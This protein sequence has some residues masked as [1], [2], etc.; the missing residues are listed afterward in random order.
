MQFGLMFNRQSR[1]M[2]IRG[3]LSRQPDACSQ[4][5]DKIKMTRSRLEDLCR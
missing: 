2:E 3:H 5:I 1:E 4:V